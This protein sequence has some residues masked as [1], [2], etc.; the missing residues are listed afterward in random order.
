[1]D[2]VLKISIN[3]HDIDNFVLMM[4]YDMFVDD[5]K[6]CFL[7]LAV[8]SLAIEFLV[9]YQKK[10]M[11]EIVVFNCMVNFPIQE[12]LINHKA[13]EGAYENTTNGGWN[14]SPL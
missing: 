7:F 13:I 4:E 8:S 6:I 9:I 12:H 2:Q 3:L 10:I 11:F 14:H 1:M 5:F